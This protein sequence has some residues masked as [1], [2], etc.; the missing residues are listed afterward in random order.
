[1]SSVACVVIS[2]DGKTFASNSSGNCS[3]LWNLD[4]G[5]LI[6][7][8]SGHSVA[9][10][11][12]A[13]NPN[14]K[15]L[16]SGSYDRTIKLWNLETGQMKQPCKFSVLDREDWEDD[17]IQKVSKLYSSSKTSDQASEVN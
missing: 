5:E 17:R 16:A 11:C 1:M 14:G 15:I 2:P 12:V 8:F 3:K 10:Y 9:V 13:I 7:T 6:R 4:T